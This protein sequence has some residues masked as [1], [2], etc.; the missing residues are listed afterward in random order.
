LNEPTNPN[1]H[2]IVATCATYGLCW[3]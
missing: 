2:R 1:H 3:I